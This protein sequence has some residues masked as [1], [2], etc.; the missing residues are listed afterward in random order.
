MKSAHVGYQCLQGKDLAN[1]PL[2]QA[3]TRQHFKKE[4]MFW[5]RRELYTELILSF[6]KQEWG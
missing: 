6:V 1:K 4:R 3:P 5:T 2:C